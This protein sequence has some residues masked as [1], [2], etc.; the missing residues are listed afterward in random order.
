MQDHQDY[1]KEAITP[2]IIP[3]MR[4]VEDQADKLDI[5]APDIIKICILI[6]VLHGTL[7]EKITRESIKGLDAMYNML[8]DSL[9]FERDVLLI[10]AAEFEKARYNKERQ[11]EN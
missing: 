11:S 6:N 3:I 4:A 8:Q 10:V 2:M 5:A 7:T 1:I 9:V